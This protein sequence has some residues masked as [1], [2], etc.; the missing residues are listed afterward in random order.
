M[1]QYVTEHPKLTIIQ[2]KFLLEAIEQG[3]EV[4]VVESNSELISTKN[5]IW[6]QATDQRGYYDE[7][8]DKSTSVGFALILKDLIQDVPIWGELT[9][10]DKHQILDLKGLLE[11]SEEEA[12]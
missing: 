9:D 5:K 4:E 10:D 1:K 7:M 11:E 2:K 8:L 12:A 3:R 6:V